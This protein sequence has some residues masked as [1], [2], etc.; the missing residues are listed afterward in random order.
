MQLHP[1]LF[2]RSY[3]KNYVGLKSMQ[4][5]VGLK[6]K[7]PILEAFQDDNHKNNKKLYIN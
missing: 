7:Y 6:R 2:C 5:I 3:D 4:T 1:K